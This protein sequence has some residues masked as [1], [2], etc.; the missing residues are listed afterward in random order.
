MVCVIGENLT[1]LHHLPPSVL[2]SLPIVWN[3]YGLMHMEL[4][5]CNSSLPQRGTGR[6]PCTEQLNDFANFGK[7]NI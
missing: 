6:Y 5:T 3:S 1:A 2:L 7:P 4:F